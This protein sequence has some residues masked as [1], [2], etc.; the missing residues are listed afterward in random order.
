[1]TFSVLD[2]AEGTCYY[3][4]CSLFRKKI[5]RT[6][7]FPK[8]IFYYGC[9]VTTYWDRSQHTM[10]DEA[11]QHYLRLDFH[12]WFNF[13][14]VPLLKLKC[15]YKNTFNTI[16]KHKNFYHSNCID[17]VLGIRCIRGQCPVQEVIVIYLLYLVNY[18][19]CGLELWHGD[20]ESNKRLKGDII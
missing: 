10:Q 1:M 6:I 7:F 4:M 17:V 3:S 12:Y 14:E 19:R 5:N 8:W 15:M 13:G 11:A 16:S 9:R 20:G 2:V 18:F